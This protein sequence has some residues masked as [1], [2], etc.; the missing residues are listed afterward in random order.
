V[1]ERKPVPYGGPEGVQGLSHIAIAVREADALVKTLVEALG[2]RRGAEE[3]LDDG[4]LRVV[5]V[6]LGPVTLEL[7]EP[8]RADHTVARFLETRGPGLHHVSLEV[9]D[10]AAH[11]ARARASGVRVIDEAPRAGA[12]GSR[13]AFL[14][15]KS[16]GGVLVELCEAGKRAEEPPL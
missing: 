8:R 16:L 9:E 4:G 14:H 2:A 1:S 7:L 15:P 3:L 13:V 6:H 5:F 12:H 11:L 10:V